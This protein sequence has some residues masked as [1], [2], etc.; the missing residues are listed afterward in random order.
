MCQAS[1]VPRFSGTRAAGTLRKV[2][3]G[4]EPGHGRPVWYRKRSCDHTYTDLNPLTDVI[5]PDLFCLNV[6]ALD[7]CLQRSSTMVRIEMRG[8]FP[9]QIHSGPWWLVTQMDQVS[10]PLV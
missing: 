5:H 8:N 6:G 9:Q 3:N 2:A 10:I 1:H 7:Q 4:P